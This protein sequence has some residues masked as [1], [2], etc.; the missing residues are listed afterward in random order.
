MDTCFPQTLHN[1]ATSRWRRCYN[2]SWP[3]RG[4][5]CGDQLNI[6]ECCNFNTNDTPLQTDEACGA[7]ES[8]NDRMGK[9]TSSHCSPKWAEGGHAEP[10][11]GLAKGRSRWLCPPY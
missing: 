9:A 2:Q 4:R 11:I 10:V 3:F 5:N 8:K 7:G 6:R 1:I